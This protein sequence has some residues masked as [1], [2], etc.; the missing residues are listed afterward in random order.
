MGLDRLLEGLLGVDRHQ[1]AS[2]VTS[3]C[4]G[5]GGGDERLAVLAE[6]SPHRILRPRNHFIEPRVARSRLRT[7]RSCSLAGGTGKTMSDA[8]SRRIPMENRYS[9]VHPRSKESL[10][11][12]RP[13]A[14]RAEVRPER[15]CRG[16]EPD[17]APSGSN[18]RQLHPATWRIFLTTLIL[19]PP[20][21]RA[22]HLNAGEARPIRWAECHR[23]E[24]IA[25]LLASSRRLRCEDMDS[26]STRRAASVAYLAQLNC[27]A[28]SSERH[29]ANVVGTRPS[30]SSPESVHRHAR[31]EPLRHGLGDERLPLLLEQFDEALLLPYDVVDGA[32]LSVEEGDNAV[33][34]LQAAATIM[35]KFRTD[36]SRIP[37]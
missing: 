35:G 6:S 36:S 33:L 34:T 16:N 24:V 21:H 28:L 29:P 22:R 30:Q 4:A 14:R 25:D 9:Q 3:I 18:T 27:E 10:L 7:M 23:L 11:R 15:C 1:A 37:W 26:D 5:H 19:A 20:S 17:G 12:S 13:I 31:V 32:G 8:V 2:P